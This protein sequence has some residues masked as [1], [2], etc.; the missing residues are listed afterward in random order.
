MQEID[1][2]KIPPTPCTDHEMQSH[3]QSRYDGQRVLKGTRGESRHLRARRRVIP[4]PDDKLGFE[5][6][7]ELHCAPSCLANQLVYRHRR[8]AIRARC[9]ITHRLFSEMFNMVQIS[10]L[11]TPFTSRK[12]NTAATFFGSLVEHSWKV[13]Q[14]TSLS[15]L[16]PGLDHS[17][18][19][20]S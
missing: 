11:S 7:K 2:L 9:S 12:L 18:G 10:L 4:H 17:C 3:L 20:S 5:P 13:F 15:R 1:L 14:N 8:N 16:A 19:P 6:A